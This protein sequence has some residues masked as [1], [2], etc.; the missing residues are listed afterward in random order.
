MDKL[1][2]GLTQPQ[3]KQL[4]ASLLEMKR[5]QRI[6]DDD[7]EDPDQMCFSVEADAQAPSSDSHSPVGS[8]KTT[9]TCSICI[10]TVGD[11][12]A[13]TAVTLQACNHVFH[14]DCLAEWLSH[15]QQH[16]P[17]CRTDVIYSPDMMDEAYRLRGNISK[18]FYCCMS[19]VL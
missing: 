1:L 10:H 9:T 12:D 13:D 3:K 11:A 19:T 15:G 5:K 2:E 14:K 17:Y 16:C 7:H 8:R 6:K 4:L 18:R